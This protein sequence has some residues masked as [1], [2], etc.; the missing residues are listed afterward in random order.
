MTSLPDDPLGDGGIP[1]YAARLR[2]GAIAATAA[3]EAYLARIEA[4]EP[5]LGAFEL[6]TA[7]TA[8]ATAR[9]IDALLAVGHDLGPLMGVPVAVKDLFAIDGTPVT[10]GSNVD[11]ADLIGDEGSFVK[12]MRRAG[13][14]LLG[15]TK[16]VEFALGPTGVN[17]VRGTPWNPCDAVDHRAPGGSS[18]G[19][20]VA[21]AA[22]LCAFSIG[23]DTGGSVRIPAAFCGIFGLK[24][25]VG[26]W[27][28]DGVFP[29]SRTLDTIGPFTRTAADAAQVYAGLQNVAAPGPAPLKGMRLGKPVGYYY[30][31]LDADVARC[32][33]A[34]LAR[35]QEAGVEL[36]PIEVPE[37]AERMA[38]FPLI[39]PAELISE[40]GP[41][42]FHA[43]QNAM[44]PTVR[45]RA[46]GG[47][48]VAAHDYARALRRHRELT[49]LASARMQDLDGWITPS[50]VMVPPVLAD[51]PDTAAELAL[52]PRVTQNSQPGNLF[53]QCGVSLPIHGLGSELPVGLQLMGAPGTEAG[54]LSVAMA[55]ESVLPPGPLPNLAPFL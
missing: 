7:E 41:E 37:A 45:T 33:E 47:L 29:L 49:A 48:E 52:A 11:V 17:H 38:V 36:V 31:N 30:D 39:A 51:F 32:T 12:M 55:V 23:S 15:K 46:A 54:L 35:L 6:V 40:L 26:L 3:T 25:T 14:I 27:P 19:S 34:A 1:G 50:T 13:C 2:G 20:A 18:A 24:T 4:L 28:T 16:T 5:R 42:R 43:G 10:A 22:G 53:G 44:D 8:L 9:A 21:M